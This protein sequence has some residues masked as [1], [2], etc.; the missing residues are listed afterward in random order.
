[1]TKLKIFSGSSNK[2]LTKEICKHLDEPFG[3]VYLH[4]FPSGEKYCQYKENIRGQ[5]VFIV[6]SLNSPVNDNLMELLVMIDAA[7]R[8]SASRITAV[9]PYMG[10]LRQD[11]KTKSRTPITGRLI[12]DMIEAT[13]VN[14]IISMDFHCSQAQ[15]FF[16]I[17]VDHLY[18]TPVIAE[19]VAGD[20]DVVVSPDVGGVKRAHAYAQTLKADFAFIAKKRVSDTEVSASEISGDVNNK[21]V[22]IVDDMTESCGTLLSAAEICK[23]S[24]AKKVRCAVTH[25][26]FTTTARDRLQEQ[27]H[28]KSVIDEFIFTDTV[29]NKVV[30]AMNFPFSSRLSVAQLLSRAIKRTNTNQS[31]SA[32]F[33]VEGF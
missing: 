16:N 25:G 24:G 26:V 5:D 23:R 8:A 33:Q 12:A 2:R 27:C 4:E 22:L 6:Q 10:Y 14:R 13:G 7:R 30:D 28:S 9:I 19:Y 20:V 32:L 17:P 21:N 15:G 18:A 1:M 11:R 29:D 3:N 31:I